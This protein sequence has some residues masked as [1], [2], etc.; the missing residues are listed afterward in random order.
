MFFAVYPTLNPQTLLASVTFRPGVVDE[1]PVTSEDP[2]KP[3]SSSGTKP[4]SYPNPVPVVSVTAAGVFPPD[5]NSLP[6]VIGVL[7]GEFTMV[8][9]GVVKAEGVSNL[10]GSKFSNKLALPV[11]ALPVNVTASLPISGSVFFSPST[12]YS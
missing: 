1:V 8:S 12:V 9:L 11:I 4:L 2:P 5:D 3:K 10:T 6:V 7:D